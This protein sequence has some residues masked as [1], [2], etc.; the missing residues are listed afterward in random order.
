MTPRTLLFGATSIL[1]FSLA[2]QFSATVVPFITRAN[3]ALSIRQWPVLNLEDPV[4][5]ATIFRQY[6]PDLLL[7]CHAVCDV[8][9]CEAAPDWA[10][11]VN[12]T[13][14]ARAI[15]ALPATTR[16]VYVSSD[17]VF[18]GDGSYDEESLPCPI[19]VYGRT[20]VVAEELVMNRP[21]SLI[22]RVGLPIGP[23]PNGRTG[24]WDWLRYR[25]RRNLPVTI[26]HDEYRSV[27]W[28]DEL[29]TR[30]MRLAESSESGIRHVS[31]TRAVSRVDLANHLL[32]IFGE[33]ATYESESRHQRSAP[34]IGRVELASRYRGA[35]FE[36]LASVL[37][38]IDRR[39]SLFDD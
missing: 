31:A 37:D 29:A 39:P 28:A 12:I 21:G 14:L 35:L 5:P 1:G 3:R 20:R 34:H 4:W 2:R 6:K 19:S 18:G 26:V 38:E 24:H 15:A 8:P 32:S 13:Y 23:S 10:R 33:P 7:Y 27:V 11:E 9:R 22:I 25:I 36:P 16:L 30:V 17:H